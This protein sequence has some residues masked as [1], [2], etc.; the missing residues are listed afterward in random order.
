MESSYYNGR[1]MEND[2]E[3]QCLF[4]QE[5]SG[6]AYWNDV[7]MLLGEKRILKGELRQHNNNINIL[8]S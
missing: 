2:E 8:V 4:P 7:R 6:M 5:V 3:N 1:K